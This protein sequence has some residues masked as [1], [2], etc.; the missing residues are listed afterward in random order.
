MVP[1]ALSDIG[2]SDIERLIETGR[3]EDDTIEFKQSFKGGNDYAALNEKGREQSLDALVREVLAFLN[4]RG[5]DLIVGIRESDGS[6]AVAEEITPVAN[7]YDTADRVA[8]GLAAII[9]PAQTSVAI[10]A[11]NH[12]SD[13]SKG[14]LVDPRSPVSSRA[15]SL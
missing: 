4:T 2:W 10:R 14:V 13:A 12:P 5:G 8:R 6:I 15:S 11:V 9:E 3:A 1:A 7:A